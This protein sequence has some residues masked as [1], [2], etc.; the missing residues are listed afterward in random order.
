M[1][2]TKA[3]AK[4]AK[5]KIGS[6]RVDNGERSARYSPL[7]DYFQFASMLQVKIGGRNVGAYVLKKGENN[8]KVRFGWECQGIHSTLRVEQIDPVF[9]A[10]EIGLKDTPHNEEL[11]IH[12]GSFT[13]DK[14]RQQQL[15]ELMQKAPGDELRYL[16]MGER[17]RVKELNDAGIRKP[18]FLR[19]YATYTHEPDT[20]GAADQLEKVLARIERLWKGFTGELAEVQ[21]TRTE[22]LLYNAFTE[23]YEIWEQLLSNKMGLSVRSLCVEE[24]WTHLWERFND[25]PP[26][27]VPQLLVL[28]EDGL[29]EEVHSQL[30]PTTLLLES[31]DSVPVPDRQWVHLKDDYI[32]VLTFVDK[33]GGWSCKES[34]M[35][36][37]WDVIAREKVYDTEIFCQV[38]RANENLVKT[39]MQRLT[40]QAN[41]ATAIA[42]NSGSFD[43]KAM[44]NIEKGIAAQREIFEGAVPLHVAVAFLVYRPNRARLDEA[45]RYIQSLFMRPAWV[46]RETEYPWRIWL[47]TIPIC[48][49]RLLTTPFNRRQVYLSGEV[50]GLMPLVRTRSADRSGFEL[51]AEA[52]GTPI[53][54]DLYQSHRNLGVF[55]TTRSGKSVLA[56]GILTQ[57]LARGLPVVALDFPKPDGTGTFDEYTRFLGENG[58]YFDIARESSNLFELPNLSGLDPKLQSERFED[59]KDFLTEALMGM[60]LGSRRGGASD[61]TLND[62]VR[63]VLSLAMDAFFG[64]DQIRDRYARAFVAGFGAAEWQSIPTLKDF[65]GFCSLERLRLSSSATEIKAGLEQVK[66]RL[67]FWLSSRV[68]KAIG[69]PSTFRADAQLLVFALRNLSND[70]DAAILALCAYSAALR[71]ALASPASIFF[72]DEASI[73][74]E[75]DAIANLI[76]RLCAN[77]A[78]AG[79]RVII[80]AQDPDTIARSA[81][82]AKILQNLSTR[83]VGRIQ[84]TAIDSFASILKYP[85]D[86]ITVNATEG[87][88]PKKEGIYSRW[89]L[90][91]NGAYTFCRFYPS[92]PLLAAV[93]NNPHEQ[94]ARVAALE[95]YPAREKLVALTE[96]SKE[97]VASIRAS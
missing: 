25:T 5:T 38:M 20:A 81:S 91:D 43:V 64:D 93:A 80:S 24:L 3:K 52:G 39:N 60:V 59:Y 22:R 12:L 4:K 36:Y 69:N 29:R 83:L 23:G 72:I 48:W 6:R 37:L 11:T 32:G 78:K 90:D 49:E 92:Y 75:Y 76:A 33:P 51:I 87:F 67:R 58:S 26:K 13:T 68:G 45:C 1:T 28:D 88:F 54:L 86:I 10:L 55:G 96:F 42:S 65:L 21:H 97:L 56:S 61:R 70:D 40:K 53:F 74:F 44:L 84:P 19:L 77:G 85:R 17:V 18:K 2:K 9:D 71:R 66:L 73:L 57:G 14:A 34:Q 47:Q 82:A 62:T 30:H 41:T 89:L 35:Q 63:S 79:V 7:E 16:A 46:C 31:E 15:G 94:S 50:P 8:F 27:P 95:R